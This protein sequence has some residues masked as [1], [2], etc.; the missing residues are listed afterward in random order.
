[1]FETKVPFI[2]PVLSLT[3]SLNSL[4]FRV[5][6]VSVLFCVLF[7]DTCLVLLP[8][9]LLVFVV[10]L[11]V[12]FSKVLFWVVL[13]ALEVLMITIPIPPDPVLVF[14]CGVVPVLLFVIL[15]F[16][17]CLKFSKK[18]IILCFISRDQNIIW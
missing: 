4:K 18:F 10:V 7:C 13:V 12:M 6:V 16:C 3:F 9:I 14:N 11:M 2:F 5:E 8:V 15:S 1:M 17:V